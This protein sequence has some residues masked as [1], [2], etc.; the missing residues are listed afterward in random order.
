MR[1]RAVML[2]LVLV[3]A[4]ACASESGPS[5]ASPTAPPEAIELWPLP[6]DPMALAEEAGLEPLTSERLEYHVHAHLDVF[7]DGEPVL[8]PG[9]IGIDISDPAVQEFDEP[10]GKAYGGIE[11][12]C[13]AP[14]ISPLH[15]HGPDGVLHTESPTE[16]P[17]TFGQF[18]TEWNV[19]LPDDAKV[20][21][22]GKEHT[23][24]VTK[25]EL[26]D[27]REIAVVIGEPPDEIPSEF[28]SNVQA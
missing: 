5:G 25:I 7:K 15:T 8:V 9:G 13:E 17:N 18:L 19:E 1:V 14:C 24:D 28:P 4:G 20:Y 26:S 21:V 16:T 11:E 23:E 12:P 27:R 3:A 10:S 2:T 6:E 22:D